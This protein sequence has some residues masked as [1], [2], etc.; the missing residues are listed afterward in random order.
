MKKRQLGLEEAVAARRAKGR[1][2]AVAAMKGAFGKPRP[3]AK[4]GGWRPGAGRKPAVPRPAGAKAGEKH[5]VRPFL[6]PRHPVHVTLRITREVGRLRRR[7]AYQ[8]F[9]WALLRVLG[10][11]NF[12]VVHISIQ[13]T[14]VHLICEA[15]DR[16]ALSKGV[17]A[18]SISAAHRLNVAI[19]EERGTERRR[20]RVFTDRYNAKVIGSARQ[21]RNELAYVLRG[22]TRIRRGVANRDPALLRNIGFTAFRN[23]G[24]R[25]P[26]PV[27]Y[28]TTWLLTS[29]WTRWDPLARGGR[30]AQREVRVSP[31]RG[32]R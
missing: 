24:S 26:L 20:G 30:C 5:G 14:H 21:C 8:A 11:W 4:H 18:L 25:V 3:K 6:A 12:R 7:R 29:G 17:R 2:A 22:S 9:R 1:P 31:A 23:I 13:A 27:S 16:L 28:P 32:E 19:G 15:D 10:R